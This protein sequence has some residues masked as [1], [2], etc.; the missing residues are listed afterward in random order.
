MSALGEEGRKDGDRF[1]ELSDGARLW[2]TISGQGPPVVLCHGGPG[3]WDYLGPLAALLDGKFTVIRFDQR[4]CGR[5]SGTGPFT[6]AQAVDDLEQIRASLGYD[7]WSV[8]GHSWGAELVLRYAA[9]QPD[10]TASVIYLAG[11]GAG[12]G[13]RDEFSVAFRARLGHQLDRWLEL[14]EKA[15]T[16][17]EEH[18]FCLLQW[19]PDYSPGPA[20][21][22]HAE[23]LWETRPPGTHTNLA[24]NRELGAERL[25]DDLL[26]TASRVTSPVTMILGADDPRPWHASTSLFGALSDVRRHVIEGAGHSP[27]S[28]QPDQT[29]RL[30]TEGLLPNTH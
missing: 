17:E 9:A 21:H 20:T 4:G 26:R 13:F 18:E 19:S 30:I 27:W 11:V 10:H 28:E 24:A 7:R 5:S 1:I 6:I 22:A 15:R 3:L 16:P 8:L 25:T 29:E 14:R 2:A 23:A 12:D